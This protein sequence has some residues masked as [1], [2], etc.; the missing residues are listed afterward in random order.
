[1]NA[2][3]D[4]EGST[5]LGVRKMNEY[6]SLIFC[7][8]LLTALGLILILF[9]QPRVIKV[10]WL[11]FLVG[12]VGWPLMVIHAVGIISNIYLWGLPI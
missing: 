1:M 11:S 6:Q 8:F 12:F 3:Y 7:Q 4:L 2:A 5:G 10:R 9:V